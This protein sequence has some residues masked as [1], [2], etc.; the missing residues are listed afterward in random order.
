MPPDDGGLGRCP[1]CGTTI[2]ESWMRIWFE[3]VVWAE[4]PT[5]EDVVE[6]E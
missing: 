6:P 2:S 4:C 1:Q 5:C 3:T